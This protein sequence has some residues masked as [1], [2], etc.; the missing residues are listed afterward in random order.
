M[1]TNKELPILDTVTTIACSLHRRGFLKPGDDAVETQVFAT[2]EELAEMPEFID[3]E[4]LFRKLSGTIGRHLRRVA[5]GR[6]VMNS[7][8]LKGE[9]A[10][11][12]IA[13]LNLLLT[14]CLTEAIWSQDEGDRI[15]LLKTAIEEAKHQLRSKAREDEKRGYLHGET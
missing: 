4:F 8:M 13:A 14:I 10:D 12:V 6:E 7:D 3:T 5:Q 1:S 2:L 11:V 15:E 9:A